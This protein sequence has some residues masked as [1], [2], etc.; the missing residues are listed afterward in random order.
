MIKWCEFRDGDRLFEAFLPEH[1]TEPQEWL[2]RASCLNQIMEER[3][4]RLTWPPRFG[5]DAGD[6]AAIEAELDS[7]IASTASHPMKSGGEKCIPGPIEIA[8][9]DPYLHA[10]LGALL[11][12]YLDAEKSIGL[13][14]DQ[15]R[16]YLELP[17]MTDAEGLYPMAITPKRDGRMRRLIALANVLRHDARAQA[18]KNELLSATL[19]DDVPMIKNILDEQG[20]DT[21]GA[22]P[23]FL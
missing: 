2:L 22:P 11:A 4:V 7:V 17:V 13:T 6:V 12:E 23:K 14:L 8:N 15:S 1:E 10:V 21:G 16:T 20:I 19:A 9:P 3:R 18:R 5:P